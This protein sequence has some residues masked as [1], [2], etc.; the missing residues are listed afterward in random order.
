[1]GAAALGGGARPMLVGERVNSVG[2]RR[3][4]RLLLKDDYDGVLQV[5][6]EQVEGGAHTLDVCVAMT[7]RTDE[8]VQ[9]SALV[10]KLSLGVETPLVIDSTEWPVME[11]ALKLYP[12]RAI[13][14]SINL[15]NR[16]ERA[17][18]IRPLAAEHG[19][20]VVAMTIDEQ[21][22]AKTAD[23][24]FEIARRIH[25]IATEEYGLAPD[26]LIFDVQ[27]FPLVTG[28]EDLVDSGIQTLE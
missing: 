13:L 5:A 16:A 14:N 11:A 19:A 26:A 20:C 28:Q 23:R 3:V 2:S 25:A 18:R 8:G 27:T 10:K 1:V 7:E 12:G 4:K 21:G 15:E 17:A 22:M 9:M 24:K 6:R